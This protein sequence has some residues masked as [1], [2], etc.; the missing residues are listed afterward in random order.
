MND[1]ITTNEVLRI[2]KKGNSN[3][4]LELTFQKNILKLSD[5]KFNS[6]KA[7]KEQNKVNVYP[8]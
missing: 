7:R 8:P 3:D 6:F 2:S 1:A 4:F 5:T